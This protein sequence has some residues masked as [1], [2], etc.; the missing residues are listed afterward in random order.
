M[1]RKTRHELIDILYESLEIL[2]DA[3]QSG[4]NLNPQKKA[5]IS[6]LRQTITEIVR[7]QDEAETNMGITEFKLELEIV[8]PRA[9]NEA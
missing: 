2:K 6:E 1:H 5:Y 7:L 4:E 3:I 8:Q 9:K